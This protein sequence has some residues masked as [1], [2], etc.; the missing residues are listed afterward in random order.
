MTML[1][2][3][4]DH[5]HAAVLVLE[6]EPFVRTMAADILTDAGFH[7][8][9]ACDARHALIILES[10]DDIAAVFTD[11]EMPGMTGLALARTIRE[12]WPPIAVLITSGRIRPELDELPEGS[13][14]IAKPYRPR[15]M[16]HQLSVLM[17]PDS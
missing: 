14:F 15:D 11:I 12:R 13:D 4:A 3:Q 5:Q 6:G 1:S 9:E 10:T 16:I 8:F 2:G 7:V 17:A